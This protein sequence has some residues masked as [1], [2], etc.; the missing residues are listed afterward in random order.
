MRRS[1]RVKYD[2]AP[3]TLYARQRVSQM[4]RKFVNLFTEITKLLY[5][6]IVSKFFV[7]IFETND[8]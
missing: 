5:H 4:K 7:H 3:L 8:S 1:I 6:K 2:T